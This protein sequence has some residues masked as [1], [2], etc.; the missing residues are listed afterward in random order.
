MLA[1]LTGIPDAVAAVC[2]AFQ[3]RGA[4]VVTETFNSN[5]LNLIGGTYLP[6]PF[7]AVGP[8]SL[9]GRTTL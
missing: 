8:V 5:S 3:G 9:L 6:T 4:A 7:M 1:T 2:M